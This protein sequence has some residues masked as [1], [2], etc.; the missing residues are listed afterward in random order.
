MSHEGLKILIT[1]GKYIVHHQVPQNPYRYRDHRD[2]D[3][4]NINL[5]NSYV[6]TGN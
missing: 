6:I 2:S 5:Q 4:T 1:V 3:E